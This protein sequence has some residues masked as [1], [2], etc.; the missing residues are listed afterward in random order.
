METDQSPD[1]VKTDS[2]SDVFQLGEIVVE[3]KS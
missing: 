2:D 1:D 3:E